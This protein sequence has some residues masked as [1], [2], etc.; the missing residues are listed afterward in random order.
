MGFIFLLLIVTVGTAAAS[1][2]GWKIGR[3]PLSLPSN[4]RSP[5]PDQES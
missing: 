1:V 5:S 3:D 2:L 4:R